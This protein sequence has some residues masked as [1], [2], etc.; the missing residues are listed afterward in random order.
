VGVVLAPKV[1]VH[2]E[3]FVETVLG[4]GKRV[5]YTLDDFIKY[6]LA[7]PETY[8]GIASKIFPAVKP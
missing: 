8:I 1:P 7:A 4:Q 2:I 3:V 5:E 6:S